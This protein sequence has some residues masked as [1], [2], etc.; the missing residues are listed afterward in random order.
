MASG[1]SSSNA[2]AAGG[3]RGLEVCAAGAHSPILLLPFVRPTYHTTD[4]FGTTL[5]CPDPDQLREVLDS[6]FDAD[7]ADFPDVSLI[8]VSGWAI[9]IDDRWIAVL[10]RMQPPTVPLRVLHVGGVGNALGLW[11]RLARGD[12]ESVLELPWSDPEE[13]EGEST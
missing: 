11:L 10:E 6:L 7:E 9:T 5:I 3:H 4:A 2:S 12:L 8:H 13:G 1:S